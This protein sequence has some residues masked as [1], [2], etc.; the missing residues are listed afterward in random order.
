[1]TALLTVGIAAVLGTL[2]T[3]PLSLEG[4][5]LDAL[6]ILALCAYT[7]VSREP[8]SVRAVVLLALVLFGCNAWIARERAPRVPL[9]RTARYAAVALAPVHS[10]GS[11]SS[12]AAALEGGL[13]ALTHIR[14]TPP[15][16]GERLVLRG[17]LEPFDDPR[18]PGEPSQA[19][20]ERERGFDAQVARGEILRA[21]APAQPDPRVLLARAHAWALARL[22]SALGEPAASIVAGELWGERADLP[23]DVRAEF[24]ETG[25]VHVLVTAGLHL[26][27]VAAIVCAL[28]S[29]F[30]LPRSL[31][32]ALAIV[33]V[34]AFALW[35]GEQLPA[36]RAAVMVT[37][38]LAA[39]AFGR[40]S[41]SWNALALAALAIAAFRPLSVASPSFAL[42]FSC[43]GAIF[44][45]APAIERALGTHGALPAALREALTLS[46]ATQLGTW[47]LTAAI[48]LQFSPYAVGA[49]LAVVPCV[50]ASLVL[51]ALQLALAWLPALAQGAGNLDGWIVAWMLAV[52]RT[53]AAL[54]NSAVP[55]TPAPSWCIAAYDAALLFCAACVRRTHATPGVAVLIVAVGLVLWPPHAADA[56][57]R[58]TVIDV[59]QA[60]AILIETPTHRALLVD[61]GGRLERG[62]QVDGSVAERVGEL[63]VVPFLLRRGIHR[64]DAIILT[65]PH[66]DHAGGVAPVL[67]KLRAA[68]LADGGQHYTGHAYLDALATA[69]ADGVPIVAPRA[70]DV[71][72]T[73]DGV[74]LHF[75]GPSLPFIS[76][77]N[78]DIND[79]SIA[80]TLRYRSF[81]MLFTGDAGTEAEQ[82]FL[83]EGVDLRCQ[84]LKVG[85][86]G[87]AYS[88]SPAFIAAVR[89]QYAII[90]V[91]R[92]NMFGHPAPST[93]ATL[94][95]FGAHVYRTDENGA[96][97]ITTDGTHVAVSPMLPDAH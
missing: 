83:R 22:R 21:R 43:V 56:R 12:F 53:L 7:C 18:N 91:G 24:Q 62:P 47:P 45:C 85:H 65:H 96:V 33:A 52:T 90:S 39:R 67:R 94:E 29:F 19:E 50:G 2:A 89:P 57:V 78:N 36:T 75:I 10:D 92:H 6:G 70:G 40:A 27:V 20:L 76:G 82:R 28:L 54:P 79:N 49:N 95:R 35:S 48:F 23:P 61:A 68:E 32:C 34:W 14:G 38:A 64:L 17:R 41:F 80:F 63:T 16:P 44:A 30:A 66:G 77:G 60:D 81:C 13:T 37:A 59:G 58:I 55:M 5:A 84:V 42:S 93:I 4:R 86:H 87:S 9:S 3:A 15:P 46:I 69:R 51:G 25:T 26:G 71:W 74:A 8:R 97:T 72:R 31:A 73:D 1:M 88:S 11:S